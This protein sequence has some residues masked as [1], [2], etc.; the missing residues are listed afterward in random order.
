MKFALVLCTLSCAA[1]FAHAEVSTLL[2]TGSS[3]NGAPLIDIVLEVD[4]DK[5]L[6]DGIPGIFTATQIKWNRAPVRNGKV[7][8]E[9]HTLNRLTGSYEHYAQGVMYSGPPPIYKCSKA[10]AAK[11]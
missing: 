8:Y 5:K 9:N 1:S 4:F 7:E 3:A 6:V 2:C 11:F 10:P